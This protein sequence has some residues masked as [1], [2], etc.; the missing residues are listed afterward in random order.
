MACIKGL[1][2]LLPPVVLGTLLSESEE[3][4]SSNQC[5]DLLAWFVAVVVVVFWLSGLD[6]LLELVASVRETLLL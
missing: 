3:S 4:L 2:S 5:L 6:Q 1:D